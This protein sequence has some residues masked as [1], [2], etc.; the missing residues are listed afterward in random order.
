[1]HRY[2]AMCIFRK[3]WRIQDVNI[4]RCLFPHSSILLSLCPCLLPVRGSKPYFLHSRA[5]TLTHRLDFGIIEALVLLLSRICH[6]VIQVYIIFDVPETTAQST[7][8]QA[9]LR[10][11]CDWPLQGSHFS[12]LAI[13]NT[14]LMLIRVIAQQNLIH[15][16]INSFSSNVASI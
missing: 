6:L 11:T 13:V 14:K 15:A 9:S 8:N 12:S 2:Y 7:C 16:E 3:G 1:M 4:Q 5:G 10:Q